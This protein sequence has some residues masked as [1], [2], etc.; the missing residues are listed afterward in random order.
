MSTP[1]K[2]ALVA[3]IAVVVLFSMSF[4]FFDVGS[5]NSSG[6]EDVV[7]TTGTTTP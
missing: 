3:V 4:L 1:V 6:L 5:S 2:I 7:T